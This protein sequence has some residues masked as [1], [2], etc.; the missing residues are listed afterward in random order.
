M[1]IAAILSGARHRLAVVRGWEVGGRLTTGAGT[2]DLTDVDMRT[3]GS[4]QARASGRGDVQGPSRPRDPALGR[5]AERPSQQVHELLD[6]GRP[7]L[8]LV[9]VPMEQPWI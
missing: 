7:A 6:A 3:S 5:G 8:L 9:R 1:T 4:M 2:R